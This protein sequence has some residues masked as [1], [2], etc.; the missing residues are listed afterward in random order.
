MRRGELQFRRSRRDIRRDGVQGGDEHEVRREGRAVQCPADRPH[1]VFQ[2][3]TEDF[4]RA[5]TEFGKFI[6]EQHAVVADRDFAGRGSGTAA[7]QP[8]VAD[9]GARA[10]SRPLAGQERL[11]QLRRPTGTIVPWSRSIRWGEGRIGK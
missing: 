7:H 5:A 2:G 8:G 3:L 4:Q 9:L 10:E 1:A 6:Q 11:A